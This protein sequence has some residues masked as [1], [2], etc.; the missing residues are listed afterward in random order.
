MGNILYRI[1][2]TSWSMCTKRY[3]C[4]IT[5]SRWWNIT[6][7]HLKQC[8]NYALIG[9]TR[10]IPLFVLY[11][12]KFL[13]SAGNYFLSFFSIFFM[14]KNEVCWWLIL[15]LVH[16]SFKLLVSLMPTTWAGE[17]Y[18]NY[19]YHPLLVFIIITF[20]LMKNVLYR[21]NTFHL[22]RKPLAKAWNCL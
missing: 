19:P 6:F 22:D 8:T 4:L 15:F 5:T 1:W 20:K 7:L 16:N 18:S 10:K 14:L 9:R 13:C 17:S 3:R 12:M 2:E 11:F 21:H